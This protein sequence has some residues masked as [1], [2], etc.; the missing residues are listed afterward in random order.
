[1]IEYTSNLTRSYLEREPDRYTAATRAVEKVGRIDMLIPNPTRI[2]LRIYP[3][4]HVLILEGENLWFCHKLQLGEYDNRVDI[5]TNFQNVTQRM[6]RFNF[7]PNE[8]L[9]G[10]VAE[11][12]MKV[13]LHNHF[14]RVAPVQQRIQVVQM[15]RE[16]TPA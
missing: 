3:N 2:E 14:A 9:L 13:T 4:E 8:K 12:E 11:G 6:I 7:P 10:L 1:M 5:D 15:E 16:S